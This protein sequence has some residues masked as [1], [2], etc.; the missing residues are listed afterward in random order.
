MDLVIRVQI[1]GKTVFFPIATNTLGKRY[2]TN[3][4]PTRKQKK[5]GCLRLDL[6]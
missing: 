4:S 1:L 6:I 5:N 2:E 3:N